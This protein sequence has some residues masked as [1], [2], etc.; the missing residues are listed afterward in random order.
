MSTLLCRTVSVYPAVDISQPVD[1]IGGKGARY[2]G[3]GA[4]AGNDPMVWKNFRIAY[5]DDQSGS[6]TIRTR[7]FCASY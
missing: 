4:E 6:R 3:H 7:L 1:V 2:V 5:R